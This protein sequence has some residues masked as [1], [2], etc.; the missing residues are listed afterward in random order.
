[1]AKSRR[2]LAGALSLAL[3]LPALWLR[4]T[5]LT[6]LPVFV[7]EGT[8]VFWARQYTAGQ[9]T[10]P[11]FMD[12]RMLA[13][14]VYARF[15]LDGP[16]P[17][18]TGR[19]AAALCASL[20]VAA[21]LAVGRQ[22]GG[23]R[24][25]WLAGLVY[26]LLP[27][28][29]FHERQMLADTLATAFG[30]VML[31]GLLRLRTQRPWSAV[32]FF[33]L[34]LAGAVLA[35]LNAALYL[36]LP[37]LAVMVW[38]RDERERSRLIRRLLAGLALAAA[39][40]GAF[41]FMERARLGASSG[42]M[43]APALS[44]V[45]CPPALCAGDWAEQ[46]RR[47]PGALGSLGE[48][49]SPYL[50]WPLAVLALAGAALARSRRLALW[51]ALA[52]GAM[53][54]VV[55]V[56]VRD[57]IFP[58]YLL[59]VAPPVV[60]LAA[61]GLLAVVQRTPGQLRRP[62]ALLG[63][64]LLLSPAP[65]TLALITHPMEARLAPVDQRQYLT[66]V[67]TG[68]GFAEAAGAVLA[69]EAG[70]APPA[71]LVI[72]TAWH[73]LPLA[74]QAASGQLNTPTAADLTWPQVEAALADGRAVYLLDEAPPGQARRDPNPADLAFIPRPGEAAA[75]RVRRFT[76]GGG[77][78]PLFD[79]LFIRPDAF[80]DTYDALLAE[81]A[82]DGAWLAPYPP[83]QAWLLAE[84][85]GAA[86]ARVLDLGGA[87]P[88]DAAGAV[89][90]L[91]D[92]VAAGP[93][94][95]V[96]AVF[97]QETRL[98]PG[99]RVE[100]WLAGALFHERER[101]FGPVRVVDFAGTGV[102][103]VTLTPGLEFPDGLRLETLAVLDVEARPGG[104]VRVQAAWRGGAAAPRAAYKVFV[105]LFQGDRL[106]AQHDG[107]PVGELRPTTTWRAGETVVDRVALRVPPEAP[108]GVYALRL[109]LYDL[110][111]QARLTGRL[112][113]GSTVEFF[114]GGAVTVR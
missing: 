69:R 89:A 88:W 85:P 19:A 10:Y 41:L 40:A 74:A 97:L 63:G 50:G 1:M 26:A 99:R 56:S 113:D 43:V 38:P 39:L 20:N 98:D 22:L 60:A 36:C 105:H 7:D 28:T 45:Q 71:L 111:T 78:R 101:W 68:A 51:L 62:A 81:A 67:Y 3:L 80:L 58:R 76:A 53:I 92:A 25:G 29:V 9:A 102:P 37:A 54:L 55:V 64:L 95:Q 11:F 86:R 34:G 6:S 70:A 73:L 109:G 35:K 23:R 49:V 16:A 79:A 5:Q 96:R 47:L 91:A 112:A 83:H 100:A 52:T 104:V 84:R 46:A 21:A 4:L 8:H 44:P 103:A 42:V 65:N 30:S 90:A 57:V 114:E 24:A 93:P 33:G 107:Q 32:L 27:F 12:G 31:I 77:L 87:Q 17:L 48:M 61:A 75:L 14:V 18:W 106:I 94:A 2:R 82:D 15:G 59:Y 13:V 72:R 66:G 108:A 110:L